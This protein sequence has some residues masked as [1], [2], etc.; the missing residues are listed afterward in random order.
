MNKEIQDLIKRYQQAYQKANNRPSPEIFYNR[1]W[2][3]IGLTI[4]NI[5]KKKFIKTIQNLENKIK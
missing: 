2:F 5:R 3:R 1:G 4:E